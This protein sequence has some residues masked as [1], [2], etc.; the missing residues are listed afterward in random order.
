MTKTV[1]ILGAGASKIAGT[2]LM[3]D[4]LDVAKNLLEIGKVE[5]SRESF[6]EVFRGISELQSVHS[7]S[8]LD[9]HNVESVFAAFEMGR[10]LN[11][12]PGFD[13]DEIKK[14]IDSM[15]IV[16][17]KTLEQT[18]LFP[19]TNKGPSPY[20]KFMEL[21][22]YLQKRANPNHTVSII[23]FNYDIAC[24]YSFNT[25]GYKADYSLNE[26]II[27]NS[28]PLL[29]LH[30][31]LN[32]VYCPKLERVVPWTMEE[33]RP[34]IISLLRY[35]DNDTL[36]FS[37]PVSSYLS[38]FKYEGND[39][40]PES[41]I[42]P[43]TWNKTEHY[44]YISNV[45]HHAAKELSEAENIFVIG[46]SLPES[47]LFFR[48]LFALGTVGNTPLKRFWVFNPDNSEEIKSRYRS[49]LGPGAKERF[50]YREITFLDGIRELMSEFR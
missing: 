20:D 13:R 41:I 37:I 23:T 3:A 46:Y 45:W 12:F 25:I 49:L 21:L 47:D 1:F 16:I 5:D 34:N 35:P 10:T 8:M 32:W 4:F 27:E 36:V 18:L 26:V 42:I 28:I 2:P 24:D 15:K 48:Y 17:V 50:K 29:K 30:G 38:N 44:K 33:F 14:L 7:K 22:K 31:S 6:E 40:I 19:K 9:I 11:K 43:P 39:I